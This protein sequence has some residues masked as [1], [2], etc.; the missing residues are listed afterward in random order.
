MATVAAAASCEHAGISLSASASN[1]SA[2][3]ARKA[4]T[5]GLGQ[6]RVVTCA[7]L[8]SSHVGKGCRRRSKVGS[9]E[10]STFARFGTLS[11]TSLPCRPSWSRKGKK[12]VV[13][14][15]SDDPIIEVV[16]DVGVD[17]RVPVT[18]I[19]GFLGSGKVGS[20]ILP[21]EFALSTMWDF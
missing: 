5:L 20:R 18:V 11:S 17:P 15:V 14:V 8:K 2:P 9:I 6:W 7:G 19:T 13:C 4:A 3:S 10:F 21:S 12:A 1:I 16:E